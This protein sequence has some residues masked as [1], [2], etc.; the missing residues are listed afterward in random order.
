MGEE[1]TCKR[2]SRLPAALALVLLLVPAFFLIAHFTGEKVAGQPVR[3]GFLTVSGLQPHSLAIHNGDLY[4]LQ[5]MGQSIHVL[6]SAG[7]VLRTISLDANEY[8]R[9]YADIAVDADAIYLTTQLGELFVFSHE[10]KLEQAF[11]YFPLPGRDGRQPEEIEL[12]AVALSLS[13]QN[14]FVVD[15]GTNRILVVSLREA[16]GI[17]ERFE[18]FLT[19]PDE[20]SYSDGLIPPEDMPGRPMAA[21][22]TPDG[23]LLVADASIGALRTYSQR[24]WHAADFLTE[25]PLGQPIAL[26][27]DGLE[28]M[29]NDEPELSGGRIHV[30]DRELRQITVYAPEGHYLF[31]YGNGLKAPSDLEIDRQQRLIF[32]ADSGRIARFRY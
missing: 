5:R 11:G 21:L 17:V 16:T 3:D 19:I 23:R 1:V 29:I 10:G 2:K 13:H 30:L 25:Q 22:A 28:T 18:L 31:S 24:G 12:K 7:E 4:V 8:R 32:V 9:M 26:A 6:S 15:I 27:L 20:R 14:L